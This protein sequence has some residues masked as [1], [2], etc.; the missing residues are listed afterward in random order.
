MMQSCC[1]IFVNINFSLLVFMVIV[2]QVIYIY[3]HGNDGISC[4]KGEAR[5]EISL[6]ILSDS[7]LLVIHFAKTI[8]TC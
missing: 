2:Y 3:V 7:E 6:R 1:E 4:N 8:K 5:F